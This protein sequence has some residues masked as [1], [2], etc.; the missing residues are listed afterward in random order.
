M[1]TDIAQAVRPDRASI[2]QH[3]HALFDPVRE[4]YPNGLI[5]I[6][7]GAPGRPNM[8]ALFALDDASIDRAIEFAVS[9]NDA[10]DN[11]YVGVNP[12]KP[13]TRQGRRAS[14]EDVELSFFYFAD[15][16]QAEAVEKARK[17]MPVK[18]TMLVMTGTQPNQR[19]HFYWQMQEPTENM[20]AWSQKQR[21]I[22][23]A[24][25]GDAVIDPPRIMRLGGTVNH[26]T[27]DKEGRG[28]IRETT[29]VRTDWPSERMPVRPE[30]VDQAFPPVASDN[31]VALRHDTNT[32]KAMSH[33]TRVADLIDACRQGHEWH[34]NLIR[35]VAHLAARGR[36]SAEIMALAA[37]VT[38]PGYQV[39]ETEREIA[40]ALDGARRKWD[41]PEPQDDDVEAEELKREPADS[42]FPLYDI[43]EL[44]ALPPPS[45]L[46]QDLIA[47]HGLSIVYGEPGAGKSFITLDMAL[48]VA[49]GM[50]WHGVSASQ[51]GVIY[52]AGEG[53][54]GLGKRI[55][56]WR[57]EHAMDGV[58]A[59]F[60][61]LPIAVQ[62]IED[63]DRTKL[64]RTIDTARERMGWD[65][66]LIVI[67]TVSRALAGQDE[68]TQQSMTLFVKACDEVQRHIDGAVI[69][70]HHSG[71]DAGRGMR[72]STVLLGACDASIKV[73]KEEDG[74]ARV[75]VEKQKD[76]EE[77][78]PIYL[79]M[80]KVEWPLGLGDTDSTLVPI[81]TDE[82]PVQTLTNRKLTRDDADKVFAMVDKGW[83]EKA[84]WSVNPQAKRRG[85]HLPKKM[86]AMFEITESYALSYVIE[87]QENGYMINDMCDSRNKVT[88]LKVLKMLEPDL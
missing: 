26:P 9:R 65:V 39:S 32:L 46:I 88:G 63:P 3:L 37:A 69:G 8:A 42:V 23:A 12:R 43:D 40:V 55:R 27:A 44:E 25:G 16:D 14:A 6:A 48:R 35:L 2:S 18:P 7:H 33:G 82:A 79:E 71:K 76:A 20:A 1:A 47:D 34:N 19:P 80:K 22:A 86:A 58:D 49:H 10:G 24:L 54:R 75:E 15:L 56:G 83:M 87:W 84:P 59:P 17:H 85:R 67:D 5:E 28:Y 53:F 50:D 62:L 45:W 70:V 72:G 77:G 74:R 38:L 4:I 68:N 29:T 41:I 81:K 36:T 30:E 57:N 52:I 11:V 60:L 66:A 31:V 78:D 13:Q 51:G 61:L 64:L 73:S 21:N